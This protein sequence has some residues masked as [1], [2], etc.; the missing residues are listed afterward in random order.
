MN[1]LS[2]SPLIAGQSHLIPLYVLNQRYFSRMFSVKNM[3]LTNQKYHEE[4]VRKGVNV[5]PI[6]FSP[7]LKKG[8]NWNSLS[9]IDN[10]EFKN[11]LSLAFDL[12]KPE[13]I[14]DA[15]EPLSSYIATLNG[16]PRISIQRTGIFR[17]IDKKQRNPR[18]IH[19][20]EKMDDGKMANMGMV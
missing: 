14:L 13:I 6:D 1:I 16:V 12:V 19:S 20:M 8:V 3:L 4:F 17:S 18:H 9:I 2:I 5:L 15:H 7:D 11:K 10:M